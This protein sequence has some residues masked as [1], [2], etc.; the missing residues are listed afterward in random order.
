MVQYIKMIPT[1][2]PREFIPAIQTQKHKP[3]DYFPEGFQPSQL[4][5]KLFGIDQWSYNQ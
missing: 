2:D 5:R 1:S 4:G 3:D